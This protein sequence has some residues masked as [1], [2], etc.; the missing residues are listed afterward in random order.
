MSWSWATYRLDLLSR[1]EQA[2]PLMRSVWEPR[3]NRLDWLAPAF[4]PL[5]TR[6]IPPHR[7][8]APN[9]LQEA[10]KAATTTKQHKRAR[11]VRDIPLSQTNV[12]AHAGLPASI[13][14]SS[15]IA[16]LLTHTP[17]QQQ[18]FFGIAFTDLECPTVGY[19]NIHEIPSWSPTLESDE[20]LFIPT[21]LERSLPYLDARNSRPSDVTKEAEHVPSSRAEALA[22]PDVVVLDATG[23]HDKSIGPKLEYLMAFAMTSANRRIIDQITVITINDN[24]FSDTIIPPGINQSRH[25]LA[26]VGAPSSSEEFRTFLRA[27]ERWCVARIDPRVLEARADF[28]LDH[29]HDALVRLGMALPH[30]KAPNA[31]AAPPPENGAEPQAQNLAPFGIACAIVAMQRDRQ[32]PQD[33]EELCRRLRNRFDPQ[34]INDIERVMR[35]YLMARGFLEPEYSLLSNGGHGATIVDIARHYDLI[36]E[37]FLDSIASD[38]TEPIMPPEIAQS[39]LFDQSTWK[40]RAMRLMNLMH[41]NP[42]LPSMFVLEYMPNSKAETLRLTAERLGIAFLAHEAVLAMKRSGNGSS[43]AILFS[44]AGCLPLDAWEQFI[45]S[46]FAHLCES[47]LANL[48][49]GAV[50]NDFILYCLHVADSNLFKRGKAARRRILSNMLVMYGI[51]LDPESLRDDAVQKDTELWIRTTSAPYIDAIV[52]A[53]LRYNLRIHGIP[54]SAWKW[55]VGHDED[56]QAYDFVHPLD[57]VA[58]AEH[59]SYLHE[60]L[61]APIPACDNAALLLRSIDEL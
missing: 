6:I 18:R 43:P 2:P 39:A 46:V 25:P 52:H 50:L 40:S 13:F 51:Q 38:P 45:D 15:L 54:P 31:D 23:W 4:F 37:N 1:I 60:L 24:P 34:T 29:M 26:R 49:H 56:W 53:S 17:A 59:V 8:D 19:I 10:S 42:L 47:G 12:E 57:D 41:Y 20:L 5:P 21:I 14:R 61:H 11:V 3:A 32:D 33:V 7:T 30:A 55:W 35:A 16:S 36:G 58:V 9:D 44:Y 22:F 48:A 28:R 27:W